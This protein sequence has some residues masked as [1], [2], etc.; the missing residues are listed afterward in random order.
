MRCTKNIMCVH[1]HP[2][3][4]TGEVRSIVEETRKVSWG[5]LLE[6]DVCFIY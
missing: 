4:C 1:A 6:A 2:R 3:L 5:Q